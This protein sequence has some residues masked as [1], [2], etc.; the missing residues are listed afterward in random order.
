MSQFRECSVD[1][2]VSAMNLCHFHFHVMAGV[3]L[4]RNPKYK[5]FGND[6][7]KYCSS[8]PYLFPVPFEAISYL[9]PLISNCQD[10]WGCDG[11]SMGWSSI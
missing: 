11:N 7:F 1:S 2:L 5:R 3:D 4:G 9:S 8:L 10:Q 6:P